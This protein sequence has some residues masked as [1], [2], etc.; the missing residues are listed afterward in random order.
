MRY[1]AMA[2]FFF[3]LTGC[4]EKI[5]PTTLAATEPSPPA[6][7]RPTLGVAALQD[8][9]STDERAG[10]RPGLLVL[11]V[12]NA[13]RGDYVT[14]DG[15]LGGRVPGEVTEAVARAMSGG[16]F[17]HAQVVGGVAETDAPALRRACGEHDLTWIATGSL[18][19][20]YGTLHQ[21]AYLLLIP[22]IYVNA[23]GWDNEKTDPL[24]VAHIAIDVHDCATASPVFHR[25]FA[26]ENRYP[27]VA[28]SEAARFAFEDLLQQLR[29]ETA[30][31]PILRAAPVTPGMAD[32][33]EA[34]GSR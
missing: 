14:G 27:G 3:C 1:L 10:K 8:M 18:R 6:A 16:R 23:V 13:R 34:P 19:H 29:N 20:L 25:E 5:P 21:N 22:A 33:P 15:D 17:G 12:W 24:G 7:S 4:A 9:R 30:A 28:L 31:H 26:V 2:A 11:G 32:K